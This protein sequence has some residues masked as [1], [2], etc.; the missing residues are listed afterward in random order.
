MNETIAN[1]LVIFSKKLLLEY[2]QSLIVNKNFQEEDTPEIITDV[3]NSIFSDLG[4]DK[5]SPDI[6]QIRTKVDNLVKKGRHLLR[7]ICQTDPPGEIFEIE[8]KEKKIKFNSDEHKAMT[9]CKPEGK[10]QFTVFPGYR[11]NDFIHK[12]PLVFTVE[13]DDKNED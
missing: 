2:W 9:S 1:I 6:N 13:D 5:D 11:V 8:V 10:V 12:V 7:N 3:T 4:I